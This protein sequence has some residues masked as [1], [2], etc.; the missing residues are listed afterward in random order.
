MKRER[1]KEK[2]KKIEKEG[3]KEEKEKDLKRR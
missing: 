3:K 1:F 2:I